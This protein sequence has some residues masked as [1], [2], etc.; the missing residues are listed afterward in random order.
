MVEPEIILPPL[1]RMKR[2]RVYDPVGYCI[3]CGGDGLPGRLTD[4]HIIAESLGGM[5]ILPDAS[6]KACQ[7]ITGAFEGYNAGRLFS[8]IRRQYNFPSK[9]RGLARGEARGNE[10]FAIVIKGKKRY[11]PSKEYP[12][13]LVSFAFPF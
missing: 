9:A 11:V 2:Q 13:M 7:E 8:P 6:C 3:Y 1:S 12:G 4:E 5:L 10:T